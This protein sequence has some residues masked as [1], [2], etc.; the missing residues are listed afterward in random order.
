[1]LDNIKIKLTKMKLIN[2]SLFE[3]VKI[4]EEKIELVIKVIMK[5]KNEIKNI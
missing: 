3:E 1:M 5:I 4:S 2:T